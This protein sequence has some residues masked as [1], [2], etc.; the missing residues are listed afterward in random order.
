MNGYSIFIVDDEKKL[1]E[2]IAKY[3]RAYFKTK[4]FF[5]ARSAISAMEA[6]DVPDLVLL[7]IRMP[8]M[9]GLEALEKIKE[10]FPDVMVIMTTAY[11]ETN[12]VVE[13][14]KKGA[15]DFIIKPVM[16][17]LLEEVIKKALENVHLKKEI[18]ALQEK[19]L[20]E[21]VPF[22]VGESKAIVK[23]MHF[24]K[25]VAQSPETPI[26]ILGESG[27]G[28]ELTARAIHHHSPNF[29]GPFIAINCAAV[30]SE[31][32]ESELF[33]YA[34]GAFSGA[35]SKGKKGLIEKATNGTLFLDEIG[36]MSLDA[37]AKLLRFLDSGHFYRVGSTT[38]TE[39][40]TRVVSATNKD[41]DGLME[42]GLFREDF[43]YR[44]GVVTVEVP[45]LNKRRADI[46]PLAKIFMTEFASIF[47]KRFTAISPAAEKLLMNH[48]W[49]GNIR[50]LK[51][52]LERAV[53][54]EAGPELQLQDLAGPP[55]PQASDSKNAWP[56]IPVEGMDLSAFS[57]TIEKH[58]FQEALRMAKENEAQAAKLLGVNY[59]TFRYRRR[60]LFSG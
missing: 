42:Q 49:R 54:L 36:D 2:A 11:E 51:N 30:P 53:L 43:F 21:H 28:K 1:A 25:R 18:E 60:K 47:N 32:I 55:P 14:M 31:L 57:E 39:V 26:L 23:V 9:D 16:M 5:S 37:Q 17:D 35:A 29:K 46:I 41:I 27:T 4:T 3:L 20:Q 40:R 10:L 38:K 6:G 13:A 45:T 24:V 52:V 12:I 59:S 48:R 19:T 15:H 7:D 56:T 58:Y 34:G 8:E 22:F 50:E 44:I 33:G